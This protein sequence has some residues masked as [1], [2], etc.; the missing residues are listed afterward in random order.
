MSY[1]DVIISN[2]SQTYQQFTL[3]SSTPVTT[4]TLDIATLD[5]MHMFTV[6]N[7]FTAT[8]RN[9]KNQYNEHHQSSFIN[10][11]GQDAI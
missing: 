8:S 11:D 4:D 9:K 7:M 5:I 6:M 3:L 10:V 2:T 1:H